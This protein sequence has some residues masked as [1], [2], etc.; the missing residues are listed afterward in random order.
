MICLNKVYLKMM[1]DKLSLNDLIDLMVFNK[2][3]VSQNFYIMIKH[4]YD[5]NII[6]KESEEDQSQNKVKSICDKC[7]EI[8]LLNRR[9]NLKLDPISYYLLL[10]TY[11]L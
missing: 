11:N 9:E 2:L 10:I 6:G 1:L 7:L 5:N 4:I 8:I 3:T